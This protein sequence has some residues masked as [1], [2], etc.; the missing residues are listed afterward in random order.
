MKIKVEDVLEETVSRFVWCDRAGFS[1]YG[2]LPES[3][4]FDRGVLL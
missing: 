3:S 2:V 1:R 4:F